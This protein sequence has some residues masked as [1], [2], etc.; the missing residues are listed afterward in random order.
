MPEHGGGGIPLYP[1]EACRCF[2]ALLP[3]YLDGQDRPDVADHAA[4]CAYCAALLADL[5]MV[6]AG[7]G[8]IGEEDPPARLWA[9]VRATLLEEGLI[10]PARRQRAWLD[11]FLRPV[12]A[13]SFAAL[14]LVGFLSLRFWSSSHPKSFSEAEDPQLRASVAEVAEMERA[15]NDSSSTLDPSIKA[16]Y[17]QGLNTLNSEI[18]ECRS[19]LSRQPDDGVAREYLASAYN[20]KAAV[21]A[22]ALEA[23]DDR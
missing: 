17:Q 14:L 15:F 11:W 22:S 18:D 13:A 12:S 8:E 6:R 9:N 7:A 4:D 20:E 16:A 19:S 5:L 1:T 23:G 21:L 3:D 10:R 2:D